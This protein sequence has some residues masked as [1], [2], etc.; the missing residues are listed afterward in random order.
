[1]IRVTGAPDIATAVPGHNRGIA[2]SPWP[3]HGLVRGYGVMSLPLSS[4]HLLDLRVFHETTFGPF[5][6]VWHCD[7]HGLWSIFVDGRTPPTPAPATSAPRSREPS[8]PGS[9]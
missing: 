5:V 3:E 8:R 2:D 9:R 1:M 7:P 6:S 4:G